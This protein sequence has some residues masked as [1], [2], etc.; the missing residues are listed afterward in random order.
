MEGGEGIGKGEADED[1]L[2]VE[3]EAEVEEK[4]EGEPE[5]LGV[6][7]LAPSACT[8]RG[9]E[10]CLGNG[11]REPWG[12]RGAEGGIWFGVSVCIGDRLWGR[13]ERVRGE[14]GRFEGHLEEEEG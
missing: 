9:R 14:E 6:E 8:G 11:T 3:G 2:V 12:G 10:G 1:E 7:E 13:W 4:V 5:G